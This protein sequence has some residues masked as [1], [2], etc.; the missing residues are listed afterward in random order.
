ME[1]KLASMAQAR[2]VN[3]SD[4][5]A[6][7]LRDAAFRPEP[8]RRSETLEEFERAL[9]RMAQFSH[10]IPVLPDEALSRESIFR[11]HD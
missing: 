7:L 4:Y 6:N 5:A 3:V 8:A 2:G 1:A 9:G 10:K 11:D